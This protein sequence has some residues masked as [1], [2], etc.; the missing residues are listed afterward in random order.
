[1]PK[2]RYTTGGGFRPPLP[3]DFQVTTS[4]EFEEAARGGPLRL[5]GVLTGLTVHNQLRFSFF[6]DRPGAPSD[7]FVKTATKQQVSRFAVLKGLEMAFILAHFDLQEKS[8]LLDFIYGVERPFDPKSGKGNV[9]RGE[10]IQTDPGQTESKISAFYLKTGRRTKDVLK[11]T[12]PSTALQLDV[13][14]LVAAQVFP[15]TNRERARWAGNI[16]SLSDQSR[17]Q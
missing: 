15:S 1:M 8:G 10:V 16:Y 14:E 13:G 4:R 9:A 17:I 3:S 5:H 11:I 6:R 7:I 12:N 2:N